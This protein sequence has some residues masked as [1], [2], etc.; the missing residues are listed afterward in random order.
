MYIPLTDVVTCPRCGPDHALVLLVERSGERRVLEGEFGCPACRQRFP[1]VG[2][3]ADLRAGTGAASEPAPPAPA[4]GADGDGPAP[5]AAAAEGLAALLGLAAATGFVTLVGNVAR[6]A[7][8]IAALVE[9]VEVVVAGDGVE[10]WAEAPGVSRV[11]IDGRLPFRGWS[12]RGVALSGAAADALVEEG[13]RVLVPGG[14]L[15]LEGASPDAA[16][17]LAAAGLGV[18]AAEGGTVVAGKPATVRV[19]G[20]VP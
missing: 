14:R 12:M 19:A 6:H 8:G 20:R 16:E 9:G 5:D 1:V 13:A 17:R 18:L 15:V 10:G 3:L 2:G 11:A 4:P 7:P